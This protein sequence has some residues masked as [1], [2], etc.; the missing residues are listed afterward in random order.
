[1]CKVINVSISHLLSF[2]FSSLCSCSFFSPQVIL[3]V[4]DFAFLTAAAS[5]RMPHTLTTALAMLCSIPLPHHISLFVATNTNC[6]AFHRFALLHSLC[7]HF[8]T[9]LLQPKAYKIQVCEWVMVY[10][11]YGSQYTVIKIKHFVEVV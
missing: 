8:T 6:I 1:M 4:I 11:T 3:S 10:P 9:L 7:L 5:Q 2:I